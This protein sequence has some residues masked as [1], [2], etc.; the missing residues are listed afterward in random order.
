M[1]SKK[2]ASR[3]DFDLQQAYRE[4][5]GA[6]AAVNAQIFGRLTGTQVKKAFRR[7]A[8]ETHPDR[9]RSNGQDVVHLQRQFVQVSQ[10][11]RRLLQAIDDGS[12]RRQLRAASQASTKTN[13]A[14]RSHVRPTH[15]AET[16]TSPP[17]YKPSKGPQ[18]YYAGPMPC[19][20]LRLGEY[21]YYSGQVS[22]QALV[23]SLVWQRQ[24]RLRFG[25]I[26]Q[27]WGMLNE[28]AIA[29]IIMAKKGGEL[30]GEC[31]LRLGE[32]SPF[33]QL[34]VVGKQRLEQPRIGEYFRRQELV[35][36]QEISLAQRESDLHNAQFVSRKAA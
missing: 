13:S 11:Y 1:T 7:R 9:C 25:Q 31:A 19:R 24:Q 10:A 36:A 16:T 15:N 23:A 29:R 17:Q 3:P 12:L 4:L 32:L 30:F 27:T 14:P 33:Q 35:S 18:Q 22:W 26:A 20:P 5:F 28:S 2:T 8:L 21:L 6:S 34:A